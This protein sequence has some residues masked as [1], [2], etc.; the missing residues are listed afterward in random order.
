MA[1]EPRLLLSCEHGGNAI[2]RAYRALFAGQRRRLAS[3]HGW[4]PGALRFARALARAS[5][6]PLVAATTS[7]LLV[8]LN[9]SPH[10]PAVFSDRTRA[11]PLAERLRL[12]ERQHR[13][14][15]ERVEREI[16][17]LGRSGRRVLHLAV[18]SFT[19]RLG[20]T[21]RD[22]E[23]ALLYDSQRAAERALASRWQRTLRAADPSL[24]VRRNAPYR[25]ADDGLTSA[26]R[27]R[28]RPSRYLGIE[29]ELNQAA[30]AD[31][32]LRRR[33]LR[34]VRSLLAAC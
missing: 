3:H 24:R 18:H 27:R 7:R 1:P 8:D 14:H 13:P 11:L 22:F 30:L 20:P 33:L 6:A 10:N 19:P 12:L 2:P 34:A 26:L 21:P 4:D 29:L 32:S 17:R 28:Y 31:P 25:G 16:E 23:M 5:G 15:W 9:R